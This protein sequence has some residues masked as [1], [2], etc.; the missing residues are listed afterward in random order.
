MKLNIKLIN[1]MLAGIAL[2]LILICAATVLTPMEFTKKQH[3]REVVVKQRLLEIRKAQAQYRKT[4]GHF[5]SSLQLLVKEKLIADSMTMIPFS[6]GKKFDLTV[7]SVVL[8]SGKSEPV[9]ECSA[10]YNEYLYGLDANEIGNLN[11][12][13]AEQGQYAGLKI[14]DV[15]TPN[16][17]AGNWE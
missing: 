7:S 12:Q 4:Y 8:K 14:G 16:N 2:G 11:E 13:A 1:W 15:N 3:Q 17:N 9:M 6:N 10:T 5:A